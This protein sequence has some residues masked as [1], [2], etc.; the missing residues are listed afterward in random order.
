VHESVIEWIDLP[1]CGLCGVA[2][3]IKPHRTWIIRSP[4][5]S[6]LGAFSEKLDFGNDDIL[7]ETNF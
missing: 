1:E 3:T 4:D 2:T 5:A 6:R 7:H